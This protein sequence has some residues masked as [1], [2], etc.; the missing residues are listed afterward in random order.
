MRNMGKGRPSG[1]ILSPDLSFCLCATGDKKEFEQAT[2]SI[3]I[4]VGSL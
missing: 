2:H 3:Q 4:L 1:K